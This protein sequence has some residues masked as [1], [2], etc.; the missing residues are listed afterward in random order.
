[1]MV[2]TVYGVCWVGVCDDGGGGGGGG[3]SSCYD[4][5]DMF[6]LGRLLVTLQI[7]THPIDL[8]RLTHTRLLLLDGGARPRNTFGR[9]YR[10]KPDGVLKMLTARKR[11][12]PFPACILANRRRF[13]SSPRKRRRS[14]S[15]SS[16]SDSPSATTVVTRADVRRSSSTSS[17]S[18]SPS[19]TTVVTPADVSRPSTRVT[20]A[21]T[22]VDDSPVGP[23][24]LSPTRADLLPPRKRFRSY[25]VALSLKDIIER[26]IEVGS[27]EEDIDSYVMAKIA[28]EA[29]ATAKFRT[30]V[31]VRFEGDDEAEE[32]RTRLLDKIGVL[33]RD[34]LRLRRMLCMEKD[35]IDSLRRHMAYT[36]EELRQIRL[37][38]Y[39]DRADFGR[40][41]TFAMRHLGYR[42]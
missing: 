35:R 11:V 2:E 9:P 36:Q 32:E 22:T 16:S 4:D 17:S 34:N 25:L 28:A 14:S 5:A 40:L 7:V 37:F 42:P 31:Y 27:E 1:L 33:D 19:A 39:Y 41:E 29:T 6:S 3:I 21:T 24:P 20:P 38:C 26:S 23:S 30:E 12:H 10:T 18:D 15:R 13:C 8:Y